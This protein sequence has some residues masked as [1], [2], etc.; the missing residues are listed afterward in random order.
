MGPWLSARGGAQYT[1]PRALAQGLDARSA[2]DLFGRLL[3]TG[4][5]KSCSADLAFH[6]LP[7]ATGGWC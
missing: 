4:E 6:P 5:D 1:E 3:L 7:N 2:S